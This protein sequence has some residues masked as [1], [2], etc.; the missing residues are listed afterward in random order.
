MV[1]KRPSIPENAY[2][3]IAPFPAHYIPPPSAPL[4]LNNPRLS[5]MGETSLG[6]GGGISEK[7]PGKDTIY[8]VWCEE[9][10]PIIPRRTQ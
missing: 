5:K 2:R 9:A 1:N 3:L 10:A 6:V 4:L 7:L 8:H